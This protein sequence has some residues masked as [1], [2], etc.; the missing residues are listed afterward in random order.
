MKVLL[1]ML[2]GSV[3]R[4]HT[5]A[6]SSSTSEGHNAKINPW[7]CASSL[8]G[9][10]LI[11]RHTKLRASYFAQTVRTEK[12]GGTVCQVLGLNH[13]KTDPIGPRSASQA[14]S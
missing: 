10:D 13:T 4:A 12:Y 11:H 2:V 6:G 1:V 3:F 9:V 8:D 14:P 5:L 7:R